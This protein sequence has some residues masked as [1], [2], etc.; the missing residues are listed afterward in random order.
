MSGRKKRSCDIA[1]NNY[2]FFTDLIRS[3]SLS[4]TFRKFYISN[5]L[6]SIRFKNFINHIYEKVCKESTIRNVNKAVSTEPN[7]TSPFVL[8]KKIAFHIVI[9]APHFTKRNEIHSNELCE[10]LT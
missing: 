3:A 5:I 2:S 4:I 6:Q 1:I 8:L 7:P 10:H 9:S